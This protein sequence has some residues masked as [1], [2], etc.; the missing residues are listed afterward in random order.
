MEGGRAELLPGLEERLDVLVALTALG[1][2][3]ERLARLDAAE[4]ELGAAE[5]GE[6]GWTQHDSSSV[7]TMG[8]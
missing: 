4:L 2:H 7:A 6:C 1:E 8:L 3:D 5:F